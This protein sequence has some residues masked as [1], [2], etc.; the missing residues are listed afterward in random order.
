MRC[1][2]QYIPDFIQR[3]GE[4]F[5][6]TL[7]EFFSLDP[8]FLGAGG[9]RLTAL[10]VATDVPDAITEGRDIERRQL[11]RV[12]WRPKTAMLAGMVMAHTGVE[13]TACAMS[14]YRDGRDYLD[15]HSDLD[16]RPGP[17][18][19]DVV[20]AIVSLG[21]TRKLRLRKLRPMGNTFAKIDRQEFDLNLLPGS[22]LVMRGTVQRR[23]LHGVPLSPYNGARLSL[24]FMAAQ[25]DPPSRQCWALGVFSPEQAAQEV[26]IHSYR[27]PVPAIE[28][29][30]SKEEV[31][32]AWS[33]HPQWDE[34]IVLGPRNGVYPH[35]RTLG[36]SEI[37][38]EVVP[39]E[40][41]HATFRASLSKAAPD[42]FCP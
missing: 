42:G 7:G 9:S 17:T 39:L 11:R 22:L 14:F 15:M 13:P 38:A 31:W 41:M 28:M 2:I 25:T 32:S 19:D 36:S 18:V 4:V 29:V 34:R 21:A 5:G 35:P 24:T 27:G 12:L 40:K 3:P 8:D 30:G 20:L 26:S 10:S 16:H 23:W 6:E 33:R 1:M 37:W